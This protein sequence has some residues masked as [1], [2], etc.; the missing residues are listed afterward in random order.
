MFRCLALLVVTVA[1]ATVVVSPAF[2]ERPRSYFLVG[3]TGTSNAELNGDNYSHSIAFY[4]GYTPEF[5]LHR[6]CTSIA[7]TAGIPDDEE[8]ESRIEITL[9][10]DG[11]QLASFTAVYGQTRRVVVRV[12][13]VLRLSFEAV[14]VGGTSPWVAAGTARA[15]CTRA[16]AQLK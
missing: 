7:F 14:D 2:A 9:E 6:R 8:P 11:R 4:D 12:R 15:R 16:P 13:R 1:T 10:G 5:N 3:V